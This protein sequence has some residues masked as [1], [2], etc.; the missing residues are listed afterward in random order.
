MCK[1]RKKGSGVYTVSSTIVLL[2]HYY[3]NKIFSGLPLVHGIQIV[4]LHT[5]KLAIGYID[6]AHIR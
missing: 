2:L 1:G 6:E 3:C 5:V 4:G